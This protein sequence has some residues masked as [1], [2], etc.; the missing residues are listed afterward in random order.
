MRGLAIRECTTSYP[1]GILVEFIADIEELRVPREVEEVDP[2]LSA[3]HSHGF[4]TEIDA[5]R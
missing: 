4:H 1:L 5:D 3:L 2:D